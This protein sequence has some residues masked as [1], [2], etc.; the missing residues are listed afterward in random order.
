MK[1]II[2]TGEKYGR[3]MAITDQTEADRYFQEC[4]EHSMA[5]GNSH[6]EA[7]RIEKSNL[8]YWA[9]Y[10]DDA[11][12]E[13]V[14]RLFKCAHPIFGAFADNGVPPAEVAFDIGLRMGEA[15]RAKAKK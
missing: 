13:R 12:R 8:G 15:M 10:Y 3:A 5:H 6:E 4:I 9:G 1:H 14:E 11:T 2:T 7:E